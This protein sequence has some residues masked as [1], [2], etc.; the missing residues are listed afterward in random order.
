[1]TTGWTTR[2]GVY[3]ET[4]ARRGRS[5]LAWRHEVG[6]DSVPPPHLVMP[7]TRLS[8]ATQTRFGPTGDIIDQQCWLYGPI[9]TPRRYAPEPGTRLEGQFITPED[10]IA[11]LG[12]H[13]DEL[14]DACVP[15]KQIELDRWRQTQTAAKPDETRYA[16][17]LIRASRG[18]AR[19]EGVA[20]RVGVSLRHLRRQMKARTGLGP[21][22][23]ARR[24]Q[25][26]AAIERA[27]QSRKPDWADIALAAGFSDQAH[28]TRSVRAFT[29]HTPARLHAERQCQAVLFK[30]PLMA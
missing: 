6:F 22:T 9:Q 17:R 27:D 1:M 21:K 20:E 23:L 8:L 24:L 10:A 12:I 15:I 2:L 25:V 4:R 29:G 13:P 16:A 3:Q 18:R 30:N 19:L 7:E 26:Q 14:V 11:V 5:A 28:L